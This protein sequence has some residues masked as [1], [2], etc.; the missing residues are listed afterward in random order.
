V[1][2][3]KVFKAVTFIAQLNNVFSKRYEPNGYSFSYIYG[4]T[5][6]TENFYFP[7][8]QFNCMVGV[9]VRL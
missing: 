8:A 7:M 5:L 3:N 6:I 9:N 1:L 2:E 4:G